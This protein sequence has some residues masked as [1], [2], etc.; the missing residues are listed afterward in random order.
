MTNESQSRGSYL[1]KEQVAFLI[2]SGDFTPEEL[3]ET[4]ASIARGDLAAAE[5]KT[6]LEAI[7][8]SLS[9][10]EVAAKLG[11]D[12]AEVHR[13]QAEGILFAFTAEGEHRFPN[14]Q[15]TGEPRRPVL[16]SLKLLVSAFPKDM[17]PASIRGFMSTPQSSARIHGVPVTP[18][19]WLLHGGEPQKL[20]DILDSFL[21]S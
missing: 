8:A 13:R 15:F 2:E 10:E 5:R 11:V 12:I 6:R 17:H 21:Q 20:R 4:Q 18:V 9:T 1:S 7:N 19:D 16:P 14:W 3:A